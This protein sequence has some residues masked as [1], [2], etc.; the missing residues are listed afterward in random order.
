MKKNI[1]KRLGMWALVVVGIL[2]IPLLTQAPWS[3]G[4]FILAGVVLYGAAAGY[5]IVT[6]Q[7][8]SLTYRT[9]IALGALGSV[10]LVWAWA[11]A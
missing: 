10:M 11:V 9:I 4:D 5:E 2:L 6:S 8:K 3:A 1:T 7:F